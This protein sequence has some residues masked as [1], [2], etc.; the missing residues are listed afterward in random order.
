MSDVRTQLQSLLQAELEPQEL[1]AELSSLARHPSFQKH[2]DLWA[3]ALYE[4]NARYFEATLTRYLNQDIHQQTIRTL[5]ARAE[6]DGYHTLFHELYCKVVDEKEWNQDITT[7]A[8]SPDPDT[9]VLQA[10]RQRNMSRNWYALAEKNA[11]LLY[12]RNASL[13]TDFL[14][15]H[16]PPRWLPGRT[17]FRNLYRAAQERG[18]DDFAW[19][20][21]RRFA[22]KKEWS[23]EMNALLE[24]DIPPHQIVAELRKRHPE[25]N[26]FGDTKLLL[27]F[28]QRYGEALL[29]YVE[30]NIFWIGAGNRERTLAYIEQVGNEKLYWGIFF[31]IA[32]RD[33]WHT[34]LR[35][36]LKQPLSDEAFLAALQ[37]RTPPPPSHPWLLHRWQIPNDIALA[38][39]HRNATLFRPFLVDFVQQPEPDLFQAAEHAGDEAF[40]DLL[41][42]RL[43]QR[44]Q[45]L[46]YRAYP[47]EHIRQ[48]HPHRG[49][50]ERQHYDAIAGALVARLERL[51]THA[52]ETYVHHAANI[53]SYIGPYDI[54]SFRREAERNPVLI[55]LMQQERETWR[56]SP[57]AIREL[58]ESPNIHVQIIGLEM[59]KD[60]GG[61]AAQRVVENLLIL[62]ALLLS[63]CYIK[64]KKLVLHCLEQA[65]RHDPAYVAQIV[66]LL[67]ETMDFRGKR[68]IHTQIIVSYVRL[69]HAG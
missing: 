48:M 7:L 69:H 2:A 5:M 50:A 11:L 67:E 51:R 61:D 30:Q 59:L 4:R 40:L 42:M 25:H 53:L 1:L 34:A 9:R 44:L 18:D 38:L 56:Q 46:M 22:S 14:R 62:R 10:L 24:Q 3:P 65:A 17:P 12:Q 36:L 58:L 19:F 37:L 13:F 63:R 66:P 57:H 54:W 21:F 68:A 20:L 33:M 64:T 15:D 31:K 8:Q 52:P 26:R 29:P 16:L 39:Y 49:R 23:R 27:R 45:T 28:M 43:M 35:N 60:G 47:D 41:T 32:T 6:Q 55:Y